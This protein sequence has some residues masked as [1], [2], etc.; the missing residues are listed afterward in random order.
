MGVAVVGIDQLIPHS[1]TA[2][3][4]T[5][6]SASHTGIPDSIH[7]LDSAERIRPAAG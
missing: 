5:I 7:T 6:E 2:A 3:A 4:D 1:S